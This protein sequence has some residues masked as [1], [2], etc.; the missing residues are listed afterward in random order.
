MYRLKHKMNVSVSMFCRSS[1]CTVLLSLKQ[2]MLASLDSLASFVWFEAIRALVAKVSTT[3][4]DRL[5]QRD[6]LGYRWMERADTESV[7]VITPPA[8]GRFFL[9]LFLFFFRCHKLVQ[10]SWVIPLGITHVSRP[11]HGV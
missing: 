11:K 7:H 8:V 4:L 9:F 1:K 6:Q 3:G 10:R 5:C 2:V